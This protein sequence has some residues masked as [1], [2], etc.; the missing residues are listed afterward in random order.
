MEL[1]RISLPVPAELLERVR[2][3]AQEAGMSVEDYL[4]MAVRANERSAQDEL[5]IEGYRAM[6]QETLEFADSAIQTVR[7]TWPRWGE[8]HDP[9]V[10]RPASRRAA[11]KGTCR[12][13]VLDAARAIVRRNG[14]P[15]FTMQEIVDEMK[16]SGTAYAESSIRTHVGSSMCA[17]APR[18][19]GTIYNDLERISHGWYRLNPWVA[20]EDHDAS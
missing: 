16:H 20:D 4:V 17:N 1:V 18:N 8:G 12:G 6:A 7:E 3:S 14:R 19:H 13:E 15:E 5:A 11:S 9:Q 2:V 10:S